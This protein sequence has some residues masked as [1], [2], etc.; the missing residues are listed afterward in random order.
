M[1]KSW[2]HSLVAALFLSAAPLLAI[3]QISVDI[4]VNVPPPELPVYDQPPIPGDGYLWTP[5]YWAWSGD[6]QDYYWVPGTWVEAPQPGIY[7]L[8]AIGARMAALS[9]G[10]QAIGV[11]KW[12][13]NGGVNYGYGY[14]GHGYEGGY[15]QGDHIYYNRS[16]VNVGSTHITN[17]Y[18]K[19]V[20]N[21]VTVNRVSYSGGNGGVRAQATPAEVAAGRERHLEPTAAQQQHVQQGAEQSAA[22]IE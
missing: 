21:N 9:S 11:H 1:T 22:S 2:T 13:S 20:I 5:G 15:W 12:A 4:S 18:N 8:L 17:V 3:A 7:G 16:V 10:I 19:T 14:G 6:E